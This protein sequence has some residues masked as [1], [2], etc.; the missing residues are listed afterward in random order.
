M[1]LK[2]EQKV[3]CERDARV[4]RGSHGKRKQGRVMPELARES[5]LR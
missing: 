3:E 5:G 2:P 1:R 4:E